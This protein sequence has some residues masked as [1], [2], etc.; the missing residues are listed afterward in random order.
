MKNGTVSLN[1][2]VSFSQMFRGIKGC[3]EFRK[4]QTTDVKKWVLNIS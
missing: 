2:L 4:L 1:V 3:V